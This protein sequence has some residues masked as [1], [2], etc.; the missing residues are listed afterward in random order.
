MNNANEGGPFSPERAGTLP[1]TS[2][3]KLCYSGR[4]SEKEMKKRLVGNGGVSAY[5]KTNDMREAVQRMNNGDENARLIL[6]AMAYQ[7]AKEIGAMAAVLKGEIDAILLTGGIAHQNYLMEFITEYVEFLAPVFIFPG[8]NELESLAL[9]ALRV[10][11]GEEGAK[12]Y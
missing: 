6:K 2:L 4:F 11:R 7:I 10:L 3:M 1:S 9:G 5:L 8:E 12:K